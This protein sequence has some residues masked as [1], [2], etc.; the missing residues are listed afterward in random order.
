MKQC[1]LLIRKIGSLFFL[2]TI[3]VA[4]IA[5]FAASCA[6]TESVYLGSYD[7]RYP[8]M[9][10]CLL[11]IPPKVTV[12]TIDGD[13]VQWNR[14]RINTSVNIPAGGHMFS[15]TYGGKKF[16]HISFYFKPG[17]TYTFVYKDR[18]VSVVETEL[19]EN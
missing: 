15:L 10:Q 17:E 12:L 19:T 11:M 7:A 8:D 3:P 2:R 5:V 9:Q 13:T 4:L 14:N 6:G 1:F 16:D 18:M